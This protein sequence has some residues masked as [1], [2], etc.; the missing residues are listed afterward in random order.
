MVLLI[1]G[2]AGITGL[3]VGYFMGIPIPELTGLIAGAL[4]STPGLAV[5]IDSSNS[6]IVSIAYGIAYRSGN[7]DHLFVKFFLKSLVPTWIKPLVNWSWKRRK[8]T[9]RCITG[10]SVKN[11]TPSVNRFRNCK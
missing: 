7:Q 3:A 8:R 10:Y 11:P 1:V 6:P 9:L 5:A 4:S 2:V